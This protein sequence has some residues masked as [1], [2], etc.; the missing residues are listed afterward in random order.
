MNHCKALLFAA[1]T[2]MASLLAHAQ[3]VTNSP[4][5]RCV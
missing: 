5:L 4:E 3:N 2:M 1:A